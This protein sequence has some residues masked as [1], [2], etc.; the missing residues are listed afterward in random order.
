MRFN[1]G[2][3]VKRIDGEELK[4]GNNITQVVIYD[5]YHHKTAY[6]Y[7]VGKRVPNQTSFFFED[8]LEEV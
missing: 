4:G 7:K 6:M 5:T 2:D 3:Q 8:E 1:V